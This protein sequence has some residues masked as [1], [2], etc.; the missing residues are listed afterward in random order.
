MGHMT[1]QWGML[2]FGLDMQFFGGVYLET[3]LMAF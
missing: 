3:K 2:I 1:H